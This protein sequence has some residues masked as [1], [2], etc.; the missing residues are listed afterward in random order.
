MAENPPDNIRFDEQ[1]TKD[2][3]GRRHRAYTFTALE[4]ADTWTS[5]IILIR[6]MAW[7]ASTLSDPLAPILTTASSGLITFNTS[8][9]DI[10]GILHVWSGGN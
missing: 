3:R 8:G 6:E 4:D 2:C 7:E 10:D 1:P 5:G 9:A